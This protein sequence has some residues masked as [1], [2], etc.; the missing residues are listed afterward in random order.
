M[1]RKAYAWVVA[2]VAGCSVGAPPGFSDG[3][4]WA[5]P[6]VG[7]LE[8]GLL[9]TPVTVRGHGP[10]L[11]AI[12]P[13]ANVTAIDQQVATD[14]GLL[15]GTGPRHID[16]SET[17]QARFYAE[18]LDLRIANLAI[19]RRNAMVFPT[20]LYDTE[21]RHING[22]LG[23]DVL[24]DSLVFGFDRDQGIATLTTVKA[25]QVPR[26]AIAIKYEV[27]SSRS[28]EFVASRA[29]VG[30]ER[31]VGD[32]LYREH[33]PIPETASVDPS[34]PPVQTPAYRKRVDDNDNERR[35][36][37]ARPKDLGVVVPVPRRLARAQI[38]AARFAMHLDLGSVTSQLP[39]SRW[40]QAR[41]D[42]REAKL[43]VFDEAATVRN[44][45]QAGTASSVMLGGAKADRVAFV[46]FADQRWKTEGVEGTL[47]L[48]FFLPY[49]VHA[50]WDRSTYYLKPRGDAAALITA[51]LGRWGGDLLACPHAGCITTELITGGGG[52]VALRVARDAQSRNHP[53][54]VL[55]GVTPAAG[56]TAAS[57]VVE[58]PSGAGELFAAIPPDYAGATL[59]VLD[60]SPFP[61]SCTGD[62]GC[63]VVLGGPLAGHVELSPQA[64]PPPVA[65]ASAEAS[66]ATPAPPSLKIVALDKL[67]RLGGDAAIAPSPAVRKA[68]RKPLAV[69]IVKI[70]LGPDGKV[71]MTKLVKSSGVPAYDEQLHST[72]QATWTFE[73]FEVDGEPAPVCASATFAEPSRGR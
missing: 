16:E 15:V 43:R 66:A 36:A 48:D 9:V 23:R 8:D 46:P 37:S 19:D 26:D 51:R 2:A 10:Y 47:G 52:S 68:A 65:P 42:P 20:G 67:H 45:D 13:D 35:L 5:F 14:A 60:A 50:S 7:P 27:V 49:A 22:I 39:V 58:L 59:T 12:D 61:R 56:K 17:G 18:L 55:L 54:E 44:V 34:L 73:P 4:R 53:L 38:G 40:P 1:R 6:L 57:L 70:C 41:L 30:R 28:S 32:A 33:G 11:F 21:G 31:A 71:A 72:I 64:A 3:D 25:F 29:A 63:V 24:A 69:A 62:Q